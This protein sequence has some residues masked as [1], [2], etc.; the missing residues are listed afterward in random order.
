M[1]GA[2][3]KT[4]REKLSRR[5]PPRFELT[6]GI[7]CLDFVNTLDDRPSDHPKE[8][9]GSYVDLVRFAEDT[10][11]L[12]LTEV[13]RLFTLSEAAPEKAR[14]VLADAVEL[15]EAMFAVFSAVI[16]KRAAP[17]AALATLN[18]YIQLAAQRTIL[19]PTKGGF[20]WRFDSYG[21]SG[22]GFDA[23][24]WPIIRSAA[25]LLASDNLAF[26]RA[27]SSPTCR[28]FFLDTS[29]NHRRRW[30]SM[31]LCGNRT[32]VQKFYARQQR[33]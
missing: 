23:M 25:D 32:K 6:G 14:R 18:G 17:T 20:G 2:D 21:R 24:L 10:G 27:C 7:L 30:C 31:K 16:A 4:R 19:A 12:P 15:R 9:L 8:L 3:R 26:V 29:K 1:A 5:R 22:A 33:R 13:E 11:T 28:W